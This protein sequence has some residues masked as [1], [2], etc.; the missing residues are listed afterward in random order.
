M[1]R[2]H[3][4]LIWLC[5]VLLLSCEEQQPQ[6][7]LPTYSAISISP[8]KE[9]YHV[10]DTVVC[11]ISMQ[12]TGSDNLQKATY[13]W[14]AGWWFADATMT[15]DFQSFDEAGVCVSAPI[16]L[17]EAG[18]QKLYFFAR[19]EYPSWDFRKVEIP[20]TIQIE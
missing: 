2:F 20:I 5:P 10:G 13:W 18:E 19:L 8:Q 7:T 12:D 1:K 6:V 16:E 14:Y 4:L 17:T 3:K 11:R 15:A 9:V